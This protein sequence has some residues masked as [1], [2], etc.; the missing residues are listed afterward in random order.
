MA[1]IRK[2]VWRVMKWV[3]IGLGAVILILTALLVF[4]STPAG[5][6]FVKNQGEKYLRNKLQTN[7]SIGSFRFGLRTG[8]HL[9]QV[10]LEDPQKRLL[11]SIHELD[12]A[13]NFDALL[14]KNVLLNEI[15]LR[16]VQVNLYREVDND[17]FNFDFIS[18]AFALNEPKSVDDT[19]AS[20]FTINLGKF[21]LDSIY[22]QMDDKYAGQKI[23]A[24]INELRTDLRK[25][26]LEKMIFHAD[27]IFSDGINVK[28]FLDPVKRTDPI[29]GTDTSVV[30]FQ[31]VTDTIRVSR[32]SVR[33]DNISEQ[34]L[35]LITD[36]GQFQ[37]KGLNFNNSKQALV[38]GV[39][40]LQDH[41][42]Q[43]GMRSSEKIE[44]PKTTDETI[45]TPFSFKIDSL[46]LE[47]NDISYTDS[48]F[49]KLN[50]R[51]IDYHHLALGAINIR[52]KNIRSD[53]SMYHGDISE[54]SAMESSGFMVRQFRGNLSYSDT[55]LKL[56]NLLLKT[57]A[58]EIAGNA[59]VRI[60]KTPG[61]KDN[62]YIKSV[63]TTPGL[64]LSEAL[65]FQPD[66]AKNKYF[67][68]LVNKSISLNTSIDGMLND[69][70]IRQLV[71]RESSTRINASADVKNLPDVDRMV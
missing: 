38:V 61:R 59:Y 51:S 71:I 3:L 45:G 11:L 62:Y 29:S 28:A 41:S 63:I 24:N 55:A 65:Y 31:I 21:L 47:N 70:H 66:L 67:T 15:R 23:A 42:T 7:L 13:Y 53:S 1:H 54:L 19:T 37:A 16:G 27:Y 22:F 18:E 69:L 30:D 44:E 36:F 32:T 8:I 20:P 50:N 5:Q 35:T 2:S 14:K 33:L 25:T 60:L 46:V 39:L 26:D 10:Y 9:R 40:N 68:P 4:I 64:K 56:Q 57:G 48:S 12:V 17:K 52:A 6:N 43:V 49:P 34:P 58:N